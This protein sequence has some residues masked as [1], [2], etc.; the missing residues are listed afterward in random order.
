VKHVS[1]VTCLLKAAIPATKQK[2]PIT[3]RRRTVSPRIAWNPKFTIRYR[4]LVTKA[5]ADDVNR[6]N[7]TVDQALV[8]T[9]AQEGEQLSMATRHKGL[10][11]NPWNTWE[12]PGMMKALK[13][14]LTKKTAPMPSQE[15]LEQKLPVLTP[16]WERIKNPPVGEIQVTWMGHASFL[17]QMDGLN[18]LTD[19]VWS[20]RCSPVSFIGPSRYRPAPCKLI[21]L[22]R[23]DV[24]VISHNHY[25]HL[26]LH[27]ARHFMDTVLW[28]VPDGHR[29]WFA[30]EKITRVIEMKWWDKYPLS[31]GGVEIACLPA[32][33]WSKRTAFDD[34]H[35]LWSG[36][37][38]FGSKKLFFAGDTGFCS[39]FSEIGAKFGPFD[40]SLIPIGAYE[41]RWM[42]R[43]QH[44]DP[45][46][47]VSIHQDIRSKQSIGMHWGTWVLTDEH[48]F[49]PPQVLA[50]ELANR[51]LDP[52]SFIAIT[53]G[54]SFD[55][56]TGITRCKP[57][58]FDDE[59]TIATPAV[60][61]SSASSH[62]AHSHHHNQAHQSSQQPPVAS[63]SSG[64]EPQPVEEI[65]ANKK[66]V[67]R[68]QPALME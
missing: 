35:A 30:S 54:Q 43:C 68:E 38:I 24:I 28:I 37:G 5:M 56:G 57:I 33:H 47:A 40:L 59:E 17:V 6:P 26:D 29:E 46:E 51:Q 52:N 42:M 13:W 3:A 41:P 22:P 62:H 31:P 39:G 45:I 8:A 2:A 15:E 48:V 19:P 34:M 53:H 60:A 11:N 64:P 32:Q 10:Y 21:E 65:E 61:Y 55:T 7:L 50:R 27:T 63:S 9:S 12:R 4:S 36:W 49:E 16:D 25:D 44:V 1:L 23:I 20:D 18:I 14:Q 67:V 66:K 58:S